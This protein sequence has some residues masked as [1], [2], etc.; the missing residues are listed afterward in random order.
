ALELFDR[1]GRRLALRLRQL[2]HADEVLRE[3]GAHAM[4]QVVA[5]LR[6][7]QAHR[8][9]ADMMAHAGGAR[10][11][12]RDVGAALALELE[13]R[14]L[15]AG[16]DLVIRHLEAGTRRQR[17]PVLDRLGLVLAE[18]MQVLGFGR[19][20]AVTVDD[21]DTLRAG[22]WAQAQMERQRTP[23]RGPYD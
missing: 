16:A 3:Q 22:C 4:D 15:D 11:E 17:A 7:F 19:V 21:H 20:V 10:R 12:D 6:P 8:V 1:G 9:V 5:D 13:L 2:A 14:A 23:D 18:A